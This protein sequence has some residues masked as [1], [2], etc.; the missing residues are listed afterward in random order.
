MRWAIVEGDAA[1]W[2]Q[3]SGRLLP[4]DQGLTV[5]RAAREH[6]LDEGFVTPV[7]V[8]RGALGVVSVGGAARG[9]FDVEE[10]IYLQAVSAAVL[11]R[12]EHLLGDAVQPGSASL[13]LRERECVALLG[14]GLTDTE[15]ALAL[16]IS[17]TT[18]RSHLNSARM[19]LGARN[20]VE[21]ATLS[22]R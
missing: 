21:L 9:P 16:A 19:K 1:S 14:Q 5:M 10:R 6:G 4:S 18:V 17:I 7:R 3:I 11:R 15:I 22:N 2:S 8:G 12:S 20:R 13:T